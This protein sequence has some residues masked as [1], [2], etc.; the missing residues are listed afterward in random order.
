MSKVGF[1]PLYIALYDT[2]LPQMRVKIDAFNSEIQNLIKKQG[3][4]LVASDVCCVKSQFE[5][6]IK[7]FEEN[8]V[9]AIISLHLAY[10]PSL[11]S[12][13]SLC[14]TKLPLIIMET[15]PD[16]DFNYEIDSNAYMYNHGIHGV[17][18]LTNLLRRHGKEYNI[19]AGHY[20]HS[21]VIKD[22]CD[23]AKAISSAKRLKNGIRVGMIGKKFEGMG[24]FIVSEKELKSIGITKVCCKED[25]L[26]ALSNGI[27]EKELKAE[28]ESD[29]KICKMDNISFDFY[30]ST[31]KVAFAVRKWIKANKIDGF[32]INFQ[33][34][35][36]MKGLDT[37]PF[38]EAGKEMA[39]GI[40][41]AGEGDVL[42]AGILGAFL[43]QFKNSSF[44]EMFCP[45]WKGNTIFL[46]HMGEFNL[47]LL[48]NKH[49]IEKDFPYADS[50]NPTCIMGHMKGGKCCLLNISPNGKGGFSMIFCDGEMV[51]LPDDIKSYND[52]M[53][54][55]FKPSLPVDE[56][57]RRF[58]EAG[59]THHSLLI[60]GVKADSLVAFAKEMKMQYKVI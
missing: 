13:E 2:A 7:L 53:S 9:D 49:M 5:S 47:S 57:L 60:Y 37:M 46:S 31:E 30:K 16:F 6:A 17:Q 1:L 18:D 3:I 42:S 59:G 41:Y 45:D 58:S 50:P 8:N 55:W 27:Q 4:D 35:G 36:E 52:V 21:T 25:D 56:F 19:F 26:L 28:F 54:G 24:D 39:N 33:S 40:G 22:V 43:P 48:E 11:E 29:K 20:E 14:K 34:A 23:T 32:S 51:N 12:Y 15:T 10:S 38:S 44:C